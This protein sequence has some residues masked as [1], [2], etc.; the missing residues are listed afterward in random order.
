V[1]CRHIDCDCPTALELAREGQYD[2]DP[3]TDDSPWPFPTL[4]YRHL[5]PPKEG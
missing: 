2:R 3:E 5:N 4:P 1:T